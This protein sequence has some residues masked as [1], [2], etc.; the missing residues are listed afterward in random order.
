MADIPRQMAE[1]AGAMGDNRR[2]VE[3]AITQAQAAATAAEQETWMAQAA[4]YASAG[5]LRRIILEGGF[6]TSIP[7]IQAYMPA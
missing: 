1:F 6:D 7:A 5:G 3:F 2:R 4:Q